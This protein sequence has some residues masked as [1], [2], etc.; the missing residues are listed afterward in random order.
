MDNHYGGVIWTNHALD[1]L[2]E[3]GISQGDALYTFNN[4]QKSRFAQSKGAWIYYR[5]YGS[6]RIEIVAKK[7]EKG[8]WLIISVW[9]KQLFHNQGRAK[10]EKGNFFLRMIKAFIEGLM[11]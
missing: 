10:K 4:P 1:R 7:N 9:S 11:R 5:A 2:R 6:N 3:R 8:E